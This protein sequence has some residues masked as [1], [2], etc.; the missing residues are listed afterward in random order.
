MKTTRTPPLISDSIAEFCSSVAPGSKAE[1]VPVRAGQ[2]A[3]VDDCFSVVEQ[4]VKSNGVQM[5]IGWQIW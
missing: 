2:N 5:V 4:R 3:E 1:F